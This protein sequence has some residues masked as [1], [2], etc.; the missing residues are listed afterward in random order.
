MPLQ[1]SHIDEDTLVPAAAQTNLPVTQRFIVKVRD[2]E[3]EALTRLFFRDEAAARQSFTEWAADKPLFSDMNLVSCSYSGE[4][5][6]RYDG[7]SARATED[8]LAELR[9]HP[10]V[11]YADPDFVAQSQNDGGGDFQ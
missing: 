4:M 2:G 11:A 1:A 10:L 6:L 7:I 9:D 8:L 5:I 3:A